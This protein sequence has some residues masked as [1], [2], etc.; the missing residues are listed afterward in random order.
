MRH[1]SSKLRRMLCRH[2]H[3]HLHGRVLS[4]NANIMP[5]QL[6]VTATLCLSKRLLLKLVM[7]VVLLRLLLCWPLL[8]LL[9]LGI[10]LS[11]CLLLAEYGGLRCLDYLLKHWRCI[12]EPHGAKDLVRCS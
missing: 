7:V 10:S 11:L 5:G 4:G 12:V 3:R 6:L 2:F 1:R 8:H 9:L